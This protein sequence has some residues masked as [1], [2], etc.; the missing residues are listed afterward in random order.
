MGLQVYHCPVI[1]VLS[2]CALAEG[3]ERICARIKPEF[4][5]PKKCA[6]LTQVG[7]FFSEVLSDNVV[8][9]KISFKRKNHKLRSPSEESLKIVNA[10]ITHKCTNRA[11][12]H[13]GGKHVAFP[14]PHVAREINSGV[15]SKPGRQWALAK[16]P[17]PASWGRAALHPLDVLTDRAW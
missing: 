9:G 12:A 2:T 17:R 3:P 8:M 6:D 7:Q 13:V 14:G 16:R 10:S 15:A 11:N 1:K 5:E 4:V